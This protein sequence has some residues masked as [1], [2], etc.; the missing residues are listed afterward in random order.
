[1]AWRA[2]ENNLL[3]SRFR[4]NGFTKWRNASRDPPSA[5]EPPVTELRLGDYNSTRDKVDSSNGLR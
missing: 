3:D 5:K 1:M 4:H 2:N